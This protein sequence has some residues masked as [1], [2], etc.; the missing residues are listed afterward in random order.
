MF[1]LFLVYYLTSLNQSE[2]VKFNKSVELQQRHHVANVTSVVPSPSYPDPN[3]YR[4]GIGYDLH[5]LVRST[6]LGRPLKLG[7]VSVP[8][9][10]VRVLAHSDGDVVLHS[11]S[12]AILGALGKG[13]I[14]DYF[15]DSDPQFEGLDSAKVLRSVVELMSELNYLLVNVDVCILLESPKLGPLKARIRDSLGVLLGHS[16][17][18]NV[19]AKTNERLD[20][21]GGGFAV[22]CH[23]VALLR[24][25][26]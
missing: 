10:S 5:R 16:A 2:C 18:V 19:K 20:S 11:V 14:G 7:G 12:D 1:K 3:H 9:S 26:S 24:H 17:V 8:G 4:V 21:V 23:S 13:D 6:S 22:A 15:P 25:R